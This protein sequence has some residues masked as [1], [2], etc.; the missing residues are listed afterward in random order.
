MG[1]RA[2]PSTFAEKDL[3]YYLRMI[4]ADFAEQEEIQ[5][6]KLRGPFS[7][8]NIVILFTSPSIGEAKGDLG[9][10]L[11]VLF[12]QS[13]IHS[14]TK[15]KAIILMNRAVNLAVEPEAAVS[16]LIVLEEQGTKIMACVSS[17]DEFGVS[18]KLKVGFVASMDE[19][20]EQ[21]LSAWKVIGF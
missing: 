9:E 10:R 3:N 5:P 16:K 15:P 11:L 18:D 6:A 17:S 21:L 2:Q 13:L 12:L 4:R 14:Q 20:C 1:E 7:Q 8:K 19:I